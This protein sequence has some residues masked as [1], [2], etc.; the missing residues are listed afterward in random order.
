MTSGELSFVKEVLV[1]LAAIADPSE[2]LKEEVDQAVQILDSLT[3]H[4]AGLICEVVQEIHDQELKIIE[5]NKN[6]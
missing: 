2:Y 4:D 6:V 3:N 5:D 1:D